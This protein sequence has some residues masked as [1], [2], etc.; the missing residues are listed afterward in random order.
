MISEGSC[1]P[2]DWSNCHQNDFILMQ[3]TCNISQYNFCTL[4]NICNWPCNTPVSCPTVLFREGVKFF[5]PL[6]RL[7]DIGIWA[8]LMSGGPLLFCLTKAL[9]GSRK[10]AYDTVCNAK[11]SRAISINTN[12][13]I[14]QN[15]HPVTLYC[16]LQSDA[17][18]QIVMHQQINK[19]EGF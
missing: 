1:D 11:H 19:Q 10:L 14:A 5:C 2:K 13:C 6:I 16:T 8:V 17:L 18:K 9:V 7:R 12:I 4:H 3:L 15:T